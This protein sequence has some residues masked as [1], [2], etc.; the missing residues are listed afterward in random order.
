MAKKDFK[1]GLDFLIQNTKEIIE[2][3]KVADKEKKEDLGS[4]KATY[5]YNSQNLNT[6]KAI[7]W[8]DRKS[9]GQVIDEAL[10]LYIK[11]YSEVER[12]KISFREESNK[13]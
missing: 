4:Q 11:N 9:I 6:I 7:A 10:V 1:E 5:Y 2:N 8:F 12:V 13:S 3:P